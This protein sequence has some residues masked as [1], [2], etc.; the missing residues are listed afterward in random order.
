ME[1]TLA[2]PKGVHLGQQVTMVRASQEVL[3][4]EDRWVSHDHL[5][6]Q[7]RAAL[8]NQMEFVLEATVNQVM[9]VQIKGLSAL[10]VQVNTRQKWTMDR[11]HQLVHM[12]NTVKLKSQISSKESLIATTIQAARASV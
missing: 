9:E 1:R 4:S 7:I 5:Q 11:H 6:K 12:V 8:L 3:T 2:V 10:N